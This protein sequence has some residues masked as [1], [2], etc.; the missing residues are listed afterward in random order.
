MRMRENI[1]NSGR[2]REHLRS[3]LSIRE[4][5]KIN[6]S[7]L[8]SRTEENFLFIGSYCVCGRKRKVRLFFFHNL[9]NRPL[10]GVFSTLTT[11]LAE[12]SLMRL[13]LLTKRKQETTFS[14]SYSSQNFSIN[15]NNIKM[16]FLQPFELISRILFVQSLCCFCARNRSFSN[17]LPRAKKVN[18]SDEVNVR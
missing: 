2:W 6:S 9:L 13:L 10:A 15:E 14:C 8:I 1:V 17:G 5:N 4:I 3:I 7:N 11:C 16:H 12:L 18:G